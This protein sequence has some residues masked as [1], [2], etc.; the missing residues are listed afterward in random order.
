MSRPPKSVVTGSPPSDDAPASTYVSPS[1]TV[2]GLS[3]STVKTGKTVSGGVVESSVM[4]SRRT[5]PASINNCSIIDN[6]KSISDLVE[7]GIITAESSSSLSSSSCKDFIKKFL[8][9]TS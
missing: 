4:L 8:L 9:S 3:P 2:A 1:S 7:G 6:S 5:T